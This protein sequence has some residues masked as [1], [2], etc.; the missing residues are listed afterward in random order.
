MKSFSGKPGKLEVI[1]ES[2]KRQDYDLIIL[3]ILNGAT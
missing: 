3:N 1:C 2:G